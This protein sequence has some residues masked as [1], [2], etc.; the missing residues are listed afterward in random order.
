MKKIIYPPFIKK[1]NCIG[2]TAPS[3]GLG[4]KPI[5]DRFDLIVKQHSMKGLLVKEGKCLRDNHFAVSGSVEERVQDFYNL[6]DDP[7]INLIQPPWGGEILIELLE[8]IDFERLKM[9]PKW[10]QG[11]SDIST[12][13]FALTIRTGIAT[14]HGTNF[15]DSADGQDD[16]TSNSRNYIELSKGDI[17]SQSSSEK[18]QKD[19]VDF[20]KVVDTTFNLTEKTEWK[21]L[22]SKDC[23]ISGRVI[24][25]CF[26]ILRELIGT[27]YGDLKNFAEE[28]CSVEG[29][30]L[31]LEN[32]EQKPFDVYRTLMS[33]KY[34]GWFDH[35]NGI[36]F[37]RN[38]GLD[39]EDFSYLEALNRAFENFS[40]PI[41]YDADIGHKPPQMTMINGSLGNLKVENGKAI[42]EQQFT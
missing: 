37:G 24:G 11:Y 42:F 27:P 33:M 29:M 25:G 5:Q 17:W 39:N 2:V 40:I 34:A 10:V 36:I 14:A 23:N 32:S 9:N 12:L 6:W 3:S 1:L 20:A 16:L 15:M 35:V 8:H 22:D 19:F 21:S 7:D 41:I 13:L 31:Y 28:Y 18:W 26:D 38:T 4:P 30:L